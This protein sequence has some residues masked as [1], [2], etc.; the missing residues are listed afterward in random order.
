[1]VLATLK[2][3]KWTEESAA[4]LENIIKKGNAYSESAQSVQE[5]LNSVWR[6]Q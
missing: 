5:D 3:D 2:A 6:L 1:M 4:L